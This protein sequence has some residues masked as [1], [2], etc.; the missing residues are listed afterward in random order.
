MGLNKYQVSFQ[1]NDLNEAHMGDYHLTASNDI[2]SQGVTIVLTLIQPMGGKAESMNLARF[3][4]GYLK[5]SQL[6]E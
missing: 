3:D 2:S 6:I 1:V 5:D 4:G